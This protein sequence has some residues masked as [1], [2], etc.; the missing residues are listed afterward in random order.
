MI[1]PV[2]GSAGLLALSLTGSAAEA[3]P[4]CRRNLVEIDAVAAASGV[5][6]NALVRLRDIGTN[7]TPDGMPH[8]VSL[9]PDGRSVAF[10]MRRADPEANSYC[11]GMFV[12]DSNKRSRPRP[13]D[14]GGQPIRIRYD[15]IRGIAGFPSGV[16]ATITPQWTADGRFILYLK[17]T[18][19]PAQVWR[20]AADGSGAEAV[21]AS[22]DDIVEFEVDD[23]GKRLRF[24]TRP[25]L[26]SGQAA[27]DRE[28]LSGFHYDARFS[29]TASNR[30]FVPAPLA[31]RHHIQN[32][33]PPGSLQPQSIDEERDSTS[34]DRPWSIVGPRG[35]VAWITVEA[36]ALRP[37]MTLHV[38]F[39][40]GKEVV[41]TAAAC[42]RRIATP[43]WTAA[44][45]VRF[46]RRE[47]WANE[48]TA[49]YEWTPGGA[50]RRL[51]LTNDVLES[52]T[53][54]DDD[55]ICLR[56]TST[57]PRY[58]ARI[59]VDTGRE[60][61]LFDPNPEFASYRLGA[62]E[63]LHWRNREHL[64]VYG[65]LVLPVGYRLGRKYPLIVVQYETRGF[66]RG[67]TGD[68]YPIQVFAANG[69][70]VLSFNRPPDIGLFG[71]ARTIEDV[72]RADLNGFGDRRSVQSALETGI[73]L[74]VERGV[75][76]P[77]RMGITGLSDGASS[78]QFALLNSNLF[79]AA[80]VSQCCWDPSMA[81][82]IGPGAM[83]YFSSIGYPGVLSYVDP[84][85]KPISLA[86]N[87]DR[88]RTPILFQISDREYLGALTAFKAL[89]D[90][91]A[92]VDLYVFPDE[93]HI[94]WQPAHRLAIY[95][96]SVGWFDFWLK[97]DSSAPFASSAEIQRWKT[98]RSSLPIPP[99]P[100]PAN[101]LPTPPRRSVR[102][103]APAPTR[104][105]AS[106]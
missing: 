65:D 18:D 2:L 4:D 40:N 50:T 25:G 68:E 105:P 61:V 30:P 26:R 37:R 43:W 69:Y 53:P 80:A 46:F 62:T 3:Q 11:I 70:V 66:L 54:A 10:Q 36:G 59:A 78:A 58:I 38:R 88:V 47:G 5:T 56:E 104:Y 55:L 35:E 22:L 86:Q 23:D 19:G 27:I 32:L 74:L 85:W 39:R 94:K 8:A 21:T 13:V 34:L 1:R 98:A 51:F 83:R 73:K 12:L 45:R 6:A 28:A 44:G 17:R 60:A 89:Q 72:E 97:G 102:E 82:R 63:R 67:G 79:T 33:L 106:H 57:K 14:V 90:R 24:T 99:A 9:S 100:A 84:F 92:P 48:A 42:D 81:W 52:C 91:T 31:N 87:V 75:V 20:A 96:R 103:A 76:D 49:I 77:D 101:A 7:A 15:D 41:C 71:P 16:M 93:T 64:E 95:E 29:P